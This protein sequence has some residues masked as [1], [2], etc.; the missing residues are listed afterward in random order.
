[1]ANETS[2]W[3]FLYTHIH[4]HSHIIQQKNCCWRRTNK[5]NC[6]WFSVRVRYLRYNNRLQWQWIWYF[7]IGVHFLIFHVHSN[8]ALARCQTW[9]SNALMRSGETQGRQDKGDT[10][11]SFSLH[12][13]QCAMDFHSKPQPTN[14]YLF[15]YLLK[16]YSP[17]NPHRVTSGLFTN[18][19]LTHVT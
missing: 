18:S 2:F 6:S 12:T 17:V 1:M 5:T 13:G 16:A 3:F 14:C 19:N 15:I 10:G 8:N 4:A 7:I 11:D 9:S